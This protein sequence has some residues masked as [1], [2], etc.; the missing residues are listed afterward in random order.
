MKTLIF[1]EIKLIGL[2][3]AGISFNA[4]TVKTYQFCDHTYVVTVASIE[5]S[6]VSFIDDRS[7]ILVAILLFP[8]AVVYNI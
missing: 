1:Y 2:K 3:T 6:A 8:S 7:V 5:F 4:E